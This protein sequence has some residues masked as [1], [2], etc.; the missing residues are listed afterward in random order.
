MR[1]DPSAQAR[2]SRRAVRYGGFVPPEQGG[3]SGASAASEVDEITVISKNTIIDGNV[4]SLA[5]MQIDGNIKV[6]IAEHNR[7]PLE[8]R[9]S[10]YVQ[11]SAYSAVH[12]GIL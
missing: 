4:R 1:S 2:P 8:F 9:S 10:R 11:L 6:Y 7:V 3:V 5:N 12:V